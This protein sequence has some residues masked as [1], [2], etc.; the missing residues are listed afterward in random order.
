[1][2]ELVSETDPVDLHGRETRTKTRNQLAQRC[3]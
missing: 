2:R 1:V 3:T